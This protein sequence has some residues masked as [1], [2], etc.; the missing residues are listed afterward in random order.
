MAHFIT[1]LAPFQHPKGQIAK[2]M[3]FTENGMIFPI[4]PLP[5]L[6]RTTN[7]AQASLRRFHFPAVAA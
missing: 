5:Q 3:F 1:T 4:N 2:L 7:D 6:R